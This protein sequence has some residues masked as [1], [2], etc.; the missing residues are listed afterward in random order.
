MAPRAV[1][2]QKKNRARC[3]I[4]YPLRIVKGDL[5][6]D[7]EYIDE[8]LE[9]AALQL[10]ADVDIN[11]GNE[12]HLQAALATK[13]VFIP[14]PGSI[15]IVENY[16]ELYPSN[17]WVD[18]ISYLKTTQTCEEAC[19]NALVDHEFTY[20][21]D[22][23]DKQWLDKNNQEARGEGTS[24]QGARPVSKGK[25]KSPEM[26]VPV[27]I[28]EDEFELVMGLL[29][30]ITD[31]K[32][33]PNDKLDFSLY[34][35]FFFEALVGRP[36]RS[37]LKDSR[38]LR[39]TL[40]F[41]ESDILNESY[42]C[43]RRRDNKPVRKTRA[44]QAANNADKLVQLDQNLS[45]ALDIA[46][47]LLAREN[48]KQAA[49][50]QSHNVWR[51]RQPMAD[52]LRKFP[53]LITKA[54]EERLVEKPRKVKPPRSSLPKVKVLPP[55]HPGTPSA[56]AAPQ[57]ILPS[58]RC[59][60]I[61][62]EIMKSMQKESQELK[63]HCQVDVVDDP[64]QLC[65]VPRA[66]KMWVDVPM[67]PS[68]ANQPVLRAN[69]HAVRLRYGRGGRRFLDRRSTSH[70][71]LP[72][73][74]NHRQHADDLDEE[75][76]HRLHGQWRFDADCTL[77]G[78]P[79]E[80]NRELVDEYDTRF[81]AKRL[82]WVTKEEAALVTDAS[83]A[84]PGHDVRILP[85]YFTTN[86]A[87]L[88]EI[89]Q[90]P[91]LSGFLAEEGIRL[92]RTF[93][94]VAASPRSNTPAATVRATAAAQKPTPVPM[95]PPAAP[96]P[97]QP[98]MQENVSPQPAT[99]SS[100]S[101][102]PPAA[103]PVP[104]R[105]QENISP[106][107]GSAPVASSPVVQSPVR[108][109]T[110][111]TLPHNPNPI[112]PR[113]NGDAVKSGAGGGGGGAHGTPVNVNVN[114]NARPAPGGHGQSPQTHPLQTNGAR[115]VAVPGYAPLSTGTNVTLKLPSRAPSRPSP[116]ATHSVVVSSSPSSRASDS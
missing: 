25:A 19:S 107:P 48:V 58:A 60:A 66:E 3:G 47:A 49:A 65:P 46:N 34:E 93:A 78:P 4:K 35:D 67:S 20:F 84:V 33:I 112:V 13:A 114:L 37:L 26:G 54:D 106:K 24:A 72:E 99:V 30:R 77:F 53:S 111:V 51:A 82:A 56:P 96:A 10:T 88:Q 22:E 87:L 17:R 1:L 41:D 90:K 98:R 100:P 21:M 80:E 68:R 29:E 28:S 85:E 113:A 18:P 103:S 83:L 8:D 52:L 43:F 61:Q 32:F 116:L 40:N 62:Q 14:T 42:I 7:S 12:H 79:E 75:T 71:Y 101:T 31:Q 95:R 94:S 39:P 74:Y 92:A 27:S 9:E 108:P 5:A 36:R 63:E 44:G 23:I 57:A 86:V 15:R 76:T 109:R 89:Y 104:P 64:Y 45:Q 11:E 59:A 70:P 102:R 2:P 110:Y 38:R 91:S 69:Q 105:M 81:L 73:L 6:A 97:A 50:V 16:E 55:S 115:T